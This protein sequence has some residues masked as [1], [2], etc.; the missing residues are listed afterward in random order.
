MPGF[1][2]ELTSVPRLT[3]RI[4]PRDFAAEGLGQRAILS[5]ALALAERHRP[6]WWPLAPGVCL[7]GDGKTRIFA[8]VEKP[9]GEFIWEWKRLS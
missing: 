6:D 3:T 1:G 4:T 2:R 7:Q 8:L 9:F 5:R